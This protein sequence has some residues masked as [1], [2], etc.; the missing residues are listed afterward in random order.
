MSCL[1][2][3]LHNYV[4]VLIFKLKYKLLLSKVIDFIFSFL[5][6]EI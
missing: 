2:S 3:H 5:K 1:L 6:K 4:S